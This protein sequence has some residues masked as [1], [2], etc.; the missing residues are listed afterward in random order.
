M[1]EG[2]SHSRGCYATR[3]EMTPHGALIKTYHVGDENRQKNLHSRT[4]N[5]IRVLGHKKARTDAPREPLGD[6]RNPDARRSL[7]TYRRS[8][9]SHHAGNTKRRRIV[10][11]SDRGATRLHKPTFPQLFRNDTNTTRRRLVVRGDRRVTR[12]RKTTFPQ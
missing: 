2:V 7:N 9:S 5:V 3:S 6:R 8:A 4:C 11:R 10:V 1:R 12:R